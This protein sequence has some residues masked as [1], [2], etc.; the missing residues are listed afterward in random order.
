MLNAHTIDQ[1]RSRS[2][3][4]ARR[5]FRIRNINDATID[6]ALSAFRSLRWHPSF[7]RS[8]LAL[9]TGKRKAEPGEGG[10]SKETL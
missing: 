6:F 1:T 2:N 5:S 10:K 7:S 3:V 8:V 9:K 4:K